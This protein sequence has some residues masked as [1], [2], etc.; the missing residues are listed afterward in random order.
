MHNK[1]VPPLRG[2]FWVFVQYDVAE[3][4]QLDRLRDIIGAAPPG[5]EPTFKHPAPEYVRFER[6]PVV[7]YPEP[8]TLESGELFQNRIK[9]FDYGVISVELELH[10]DT[11]WD[12]LVRFSSRWI[13]APQFE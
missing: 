2:S 12:E 1:V 9:Y 13:N 7:E 5:R 11:D 6:P 4:I 10:F 8:V 3:Q